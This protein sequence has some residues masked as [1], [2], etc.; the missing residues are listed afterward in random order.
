MATQDVGPCHGGM[1]SCTSAGSWGDCQGQVVPSAEICGDNIDNNCNGM[2]DENTDNDHDGFTTCQGDCCDSTECSNPAEVNPG[3]FDVPGDGVDN[4]CDGMVDN[5]QLLCDQGLMSNSSNAMD[6]AKAIDICQT[7][8]MMDKKW[9]VID[10]KLTLVD[11]TGTPDPNSRSIRPHYGSGVQP[12][13]GV[14]LMEISSGAAA[15]VG[16][17]NPN[18]VDLQSSLGGTTSSAFPADFLQANGGKLPNAPGCPEPIGNT[19]NDPV[20][21]TLTIRVPTNAKSFS[22]K[23]NFFSSEFPEYTCSPYNDFFVIL[24][25]S[26]YN[27]MPANP[28]DKNLAFYQNAQM[29]NYPVG[30]NLAHG[31]TGLFTQCVNGT[32]GCDGTA[33]S[34]STCMSTAELAGTGLDTPMP[35]AC[36]SNALEG[37]GTGW[38]TTTGNVAPGEIMKLRIGIWDTSDHVL[39]SLAVIDGFAWSADTSQPG[40]VILKTDQPNNPIAVDSTLPVSKL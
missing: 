11:G 22:L 1:Q 30:V 27:G 24:L 34:I 23:S 20:M 25:D 21:L 18:Y 10:A 40:T 15:A 32:T 7:A 6:Y 16:E 28:A 8:T 4:D 2:T 37:G 39:D 5:T 38:L 14:S 31:N 12:Q 19:A 13:G 9:G 35:G 26:T 17:T 36:D 3:A 29:Q 33:G